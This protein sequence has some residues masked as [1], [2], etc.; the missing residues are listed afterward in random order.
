MVWYVVC[1]G[2]VCGVG[3]CDVWLFL[4]LYR[5]GHVQVTAECNAAITQWTGYGPH[6]S[7][8]LVIY[9][10]NT[11]MDMTGSES[12]RSLRVHAHS[13]LLLDIFIFSV[14]VHCGTYTHALMLARSEAFCVKLVNQFSTVILL[15]LYNE[16]RS[17]C[18]GKIKDITYPFFTITQSL[19][20]SLW[21]H[22][23]SHTTYHTITH[24]TIPHHIPCHHTP[25]TIPSPI[26][27]SH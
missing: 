17:I 4:L 15:V 27:P 8:Q 21:A 3:W 2:M 13:C 10:H 24:H 26:T 9:T 18:V 1:D 7:D 11:C 14:R 12:A 20:S 23:P 22:T 25:H 6:P 16:S 19:T 5:W